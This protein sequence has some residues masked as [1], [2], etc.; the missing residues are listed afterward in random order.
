MSY[1]P[2][3]ILPGE[4]KPCVNGQAFATHDEAHKSAQAR[5]LVWT[6]PSDF[7][8]VESDEPVNYRWDDTL[9]DVMVERK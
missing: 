7:T 8:V 6:M 5:F 2:A 9:G 4:S 3:F 1:K